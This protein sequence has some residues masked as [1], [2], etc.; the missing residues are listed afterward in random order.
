MS[1]F[2]EITQREK[3]KQHLARPCTEEQWAKA[4]QIVHFFAEQM[5]LDPEAIVSKSR[6]QELVE[7]RRRSAHWMI[8]GLGLTL[9]QTGDV[10]NRDHTSIMH[11]VNKAFMPRFEARQHSLRRALNDDFPPNI[12]CEYRWQERAEARKWQERGWL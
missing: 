4:R 9:C 7:A 10:L 11:A 3:H 2:D 8:G 5:G 6:K 12:R 1:W